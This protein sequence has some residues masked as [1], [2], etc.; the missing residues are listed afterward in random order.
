MFKPASAAVRAN[1]AKLV[2]L[3]CAHSTFQFRRSG[4]NSWGGDTTRAL[5]SMNIH[6]QKRVLT[7]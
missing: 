1:K 6:E 2:R 7:T 5:E 4:L 3:G